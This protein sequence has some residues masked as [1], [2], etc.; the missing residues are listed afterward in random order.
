M[1]TWGGHDYFSACTGLALQ[2]N[3]W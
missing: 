2:E 3:V 1:N